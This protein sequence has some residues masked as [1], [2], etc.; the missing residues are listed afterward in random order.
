MPRVPAPQS[1]YWVEDD[2]D[3][4]LLIDYHLVVYPDGTGTLT[5][6]RWTRLVDASEIETLLA[7]YREVTRPPLSTRFLAV[8]RK[9]RRSR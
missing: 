1:Y 7:R 8:G 2:D 4:D 6:D 5:M 9:L 3:D